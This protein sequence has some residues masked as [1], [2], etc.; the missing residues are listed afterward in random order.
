MVTIPIFDDLIVE[1]YYKYFYV[2][3]TTNDPAVTL[4][5]QRAGVGIRD[6]DS[7]LHCIAYECVNL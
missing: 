6:N 1:N 4:S 7:K 3:L 5:L 2:P